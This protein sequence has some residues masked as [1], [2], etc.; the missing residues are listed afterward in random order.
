V[1]KNTKPAPP[2]EAE[3]RLLSVMFVDLVGSTALSTVLDPEDMRVILARYHRQ[4]AAVI[5]EYGRFV[6]S[7]AIAGA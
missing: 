5:E 6:A 4:S 3:R 1:P 7:L 2:G